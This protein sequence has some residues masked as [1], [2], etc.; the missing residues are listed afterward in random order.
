M[1]R[2]P[3]L[4]LLAFMAGAGP[5][6][7][8]FAIT[9]GTG[10]NVFAID[11]ANQGTSLCAASS[12]ECPATVLVSA[13]GVPMPVV[14]LGTTTEAGSIPTTSPTTTR[15]ADACYYQ[16]RTTIGFSTIAASFT[17]VPAAT[18]N[19]VYVCDGMIKNGAAVNIG[20]IEGGGAACG[21]GSGGGSTALLAGAITP[22]LGTAGI[23]L[24]ALGDG[25]SLHGGGWASIRMLTPNDSLC[26][27][28]SGTVLLS[29][30]LSYVS[31]PF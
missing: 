28:Q 18:S 11:A 3:F 8:N 22:A 12:T 17:L 9:Q 27:V 19:R 23:P 6:W 14:G 16:T 13:A 5:A 21:G 7:A 2:L 25:F 1:N 24:G 29:G 31:T 4:V 26:L 10:L 30:W 20:I 15:P